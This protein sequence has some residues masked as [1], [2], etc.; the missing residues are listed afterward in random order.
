[1]WVRFGRAPGAWEL[2]QWL[3]ALAVSQPAPPSCPTQV[4]AGL[5][6]RAVRPPPLPTGSRAQGE[7]IKC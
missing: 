7:E 3:G 6:A 1:M 2:G 5:S 4:G